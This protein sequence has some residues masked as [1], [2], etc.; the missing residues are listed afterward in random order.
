MNQ[1]GIDYLEIMQAYMQHLR[2]PMAEWFY[3]TLWVDEVDAQAP[4]TTTANSLG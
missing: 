1:H 3:F 2:R 4:A